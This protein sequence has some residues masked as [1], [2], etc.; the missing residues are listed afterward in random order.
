V[1]LI[2]TQWNDLTAKLSARRRIAAG[3]RAW[4]QG[5]DIQNRRFAAEQEARWQREQ[6]FR[7]TYQGPNVAEALIRFE[8]ALKYGPN[9]PRSLGGPERLKAPLPKF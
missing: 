3:V 2:L 4:N 6:A 7:A 8:I 5:Q 1:F 9:P